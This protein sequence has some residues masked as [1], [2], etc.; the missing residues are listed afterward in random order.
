MN[1]PMDAVVL[2]VLVAVG[3][4][5]LAMVVAAMVGCVL[6]GRLRALP[7]LG[8]SALI[9]VAAVLVCASV[10]AGRIDV[11]AGIG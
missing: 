10:L 8:I 9:L 1:L 11:S 5:A 6:R 2:V 7:R 3:G 4:A